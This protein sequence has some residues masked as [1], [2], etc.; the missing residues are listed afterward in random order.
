MPEWLT[1]LVPYGVRTTF[2]PDVSSFDPSLRVDERLLDGCKPHHR[3]AICLAMKDLYGRRAEAVLRL[4]A[5]VEA[6]ICNHLLADAR[7]LPVFLVLLQCTLWHAVSVTA[8]VCLLPDTIYSGRVVL[9]FALHFIGTWLVNGQRFILAMHYSQH[10]TLFAP[11]LGVAGKLLGNVSQ[12]LLAPFWGMPSGAYY[13]HH[14]IMHHGANNIF[15]GDLSATHMYQRDSLL[16]SLHYALNFVLHTILY[17]PYYLLRKRRYALSAGALA[18]TVVCST[19]AYAAL[20]NLNRVVFLITLGFPSAFG[21][22][23]LM[24]GNF[25]QHQFVD[26]RNPTSNYGLTV[27]LIGAPFNLLAFN[28]GYHIVHHVNSVLH[29]S[30]M[31]LAFIRNIDRYEAERALIFTGLNYEELYC[32]VFGGR[33]EELAANHLVQLTPTH[34]SVCDAAAMLRE[35][36]QPIPHIGEASTKLD[37]QHKVL[38]GANQVFWVLCWLAGLP[39]AY[40]PAL[41]VPVFAALSFAIGAAA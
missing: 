30:E 9:A 29:W 8:Q 2:F 19:L 23:M 35:R 16:G 38:F 5:P 21:P 26:P 25:G 4:P 40:V 11:R 31:P 34:L 28:D 14:C 3:R 22:V 17:L 37:T 41:S 32:M 15:P 1:R 6:A 24:L 33:L 7:D 39:H 36:L 13:V 20:Y 18:S 27:N 10:R 12:M